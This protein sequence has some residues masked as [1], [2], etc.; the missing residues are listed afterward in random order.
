MEHLSSSVLGFF[1]SVREG[2]TKQNY[3]IT[4]LLGFQEV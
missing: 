3:R 4:S 1:E 2:K